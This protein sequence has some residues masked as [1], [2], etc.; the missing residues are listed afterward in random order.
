MLRRARMGSSAAGVLLLGLHLAWSWMAVTR[1]APAPVEKPEEPGGELRILDPAGKEVGLCPLRHTDVEADVSGYVSRVRVRQTFRNP[2]TRKVEA[3][4]TFP[5]PQDSAVDDMTMQ[6]GSRRIVGKIKPREEARKVYETAKRSGHVASLLDQERPNIFTQSVANLEPGA[7]VIIEISYVETLK[8]EDGSFEL[9]FPTVVG[10]RYVPGYAAGR[11]GPGFAPDTNEVPDGSKITPR[12]APPPTR[13]GH[14]LGIRVRLDAG[15]EIQEIASPTHAVDV[16]RD[17]AGR[18]EVALQNQASLPTKDFVL[19]YRTATDR[20]NDAFLVH[21]DRRGTFF[22][23]VL[24]PPQRV[25]PEEAFP[26]EMV[27]VIDRSGSMSGF[28]I[29]KAKATMRRCIEGMNPRDTFNLLSFSGGTGA[30]FPGPV[31]NTRENRELALKYLQDLHGSGGTEMMPAMLKALGGAEDPR[32]LR[33][34]CFMTDGYVGNDFAIIDA[35]KKHAKGARVFSFGIGGSVNR[36]LLDGM[37][38]AGRGE[39]EYVLQEQQGEAAA[40]RFHERIHSPVLSDIRIDWGGLRVEDV[41]PEEYPDLFSVKPLMI[42]GRLKGPAEGTLI[43]R[44]NTATGPFERKIRVVPQRDQ[45]TRP[46]LPSLWARAKVKDLMNLDLTGLQNN[47]FRPDVKRQITDLGVDYRLMTQFTS[48]VAVEVRRVTRGGLPD[49]TAVPVELPEGVSHKGVFGQ[50]A[51]QTGDPLIS[52]EAPA[53]CKRAVALLPDGEVKPLAFNP[54]T[55]HWE[56][57][58]DIPTYFAEGDYVVRVVLLLESG[59][60]RIVTVKYAVDLTPPQGK[61]AIRLH[62]GAS[63]RLRLALETSEETA[64]V[65]A[66]LPWGERVTLLP[67]T[68]GADRFAAT[69]AVPR[70]HGDGPQRVTYV[71]TDRAHNRTTI[72]VDLSE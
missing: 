59:E 21:T 69:V 45:E 16:R 9:S 17:G 6:V 42:H 26:K 43:L 3:L 72:T 5:L 66:L 49:P 71:L 38:Y 53:G 24:Q 18:A 40:A 33:I 32:R 46:A 39:V 44:G 1:A 57:R 37:A 34:V 14:D 28:P 31:P 68:D 64:R 36:F 22:T 50:L 10:P 30:C 29:E 20:I 54:A 8:Y 35:V 63:P 15:M 65:V 41:Y 56:A 70:G 25:R 61:G 55:S 51:A 58:F 12:V 52:V 4:Y 27:F 62:G 47:S 2:S 19:R 23:M 7:E 60:R 67:V 11:K 48:F 13:S